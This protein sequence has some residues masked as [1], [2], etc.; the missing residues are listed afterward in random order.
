MGALWLDPLPRSKAKEAGG[1]FSRLSP[2]PC[3]RFYFWL[4]PSTVTNDRSFH[5]HPP[6]L[7][8]VAAGKLPPASSSLSCEQE[9]DRACKLLSA[10]NLPFSLIP[11]SLTGR[12]NVKWTDRRTDGHTMRATAVSVLNFP[13]VITRTLA[14]SST[15]FLARLRL[16]YVTRP[17]FAFP[18]LSFKSRRICEREAKLRESFDDILRTIYFNLRFYS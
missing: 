17:S 5:L 11:L 2:R 7:S 14:L 8:F 3:S 15:S 4:Q 6:P 13:L 10:T 18:P 1:G 9:L 16:L 12:R